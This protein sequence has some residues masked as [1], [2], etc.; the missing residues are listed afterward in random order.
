MA[1][2]KW[3]LITVIVV[4]VILV[5][6]VVG[7]STVLGIHN[8]TYDCSFVYVQTDDLLGEIAKKHTYYDV[9]TKTVEIELNQD[10][11]NS[12]IKDNFENL[13][14]A[15]PDKFTIK[16]LLFN[17]KDQRLYINGKYGSI[18]IPLSAKVN[19]SLTDDG[20]EISASDINLGQ[21]KAPNMIA[22]QIPQ[23]EL[24]YAISY[25]DFDIPR[26]FD[27][28]DVHFGTGVFTVFVELKP[29][30]IK[31]MAMD[32]RNDIMGNI[33]NF[34]DSQNEIINKFLTRLLDTTD[35]FSDAKVEEYV[36]FVLNSGELVN[37]AIYFALADDLDKYVKPFDSVQKFVVDWAAPLEVVKYHGSIEETVETIL[38]D[39][40]LRELV[41]WF[42]PEEQIDE[43]VAVAEEYYGMYDEYYGMYEELLDSLDD[44]ESTF[45]SIDLSFEG[46]IEDVVSTLQ[47]QIF[48][49]KKLTDLLSQFIPA[50]TFEDIADMIDEY[51][52]LYYDY[53]GLLDDVTTNIADAASEVDLSAM[54]EFADIAMDYASQLD[55]LRELSIDVVE[56]VDA[57][58]VKDLVHFLEF[59]S[60]FGENFIATIHPDNYKIF[61]EVVDNLERTKLDTIAFLEKTDTSAYVDS[62]QV[63]QDWTDYANEVVSLL[64]NEDLEDAIDKLFNK[65][66]PSADFVLPDYEA[67]LE[68]LGYELE[69]EFE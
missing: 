18:N 43:Y 56:L 66:F 69:L 22:K 23:D 19:V 67:E 2:N 34:K 54:Q 63:I 21:K 27:V 52:A 20:I 11:I 30:V 48:R 60:A 39:Q 36:D 44:L 61:R 4:A 5:V 55:D 41:A 38:Y 47:N 1:K 42:L 7:I 8:S 13:D 64:K 53:M 68:R 65:D 3:L 35:L 57:Q 51:V 59:G 37:S 26:I 58:L 45:A 33:N 12:L 16:E 28:K 24:K 6:L 50:D 49:N 31:D 10:L 17:T 46:D 9:E 62:A 25:D 14:I 29:E 15:L 32:Y 40:G